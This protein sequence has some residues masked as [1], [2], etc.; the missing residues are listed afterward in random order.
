MSYMRYSS[1]RR[2]DTLL[3]SNLEARSVM[4]IGPLVQWTDHLSGTMMTAR[5]YNPMSMTS[6]VLIVRVVVSVLLWI[7]MCMSLHLMRMFQ[8]SFQKTAF[9]NTEYRKVELSWGHHLMMRFG[10]YLKRS[11]T[12]CGTHAVSGWL[13]RGLNCQTF[14]RRSAGPT[15]KELDFRH[16]GFGNI[17]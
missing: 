10:S 5:T 3:S 9:D 13:Q 14:S 1:M 6:G 16:A 15:N 12:P 7:E 4:A 17:S 8:W 2:L 11:V